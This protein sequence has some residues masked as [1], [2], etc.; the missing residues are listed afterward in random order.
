MYPCCDVV[1]IIVTAL[2][3]KKNRCDTK[4]A[5]WYRYKIA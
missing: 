3:Y 4:I 2:R 1:L 5:Y